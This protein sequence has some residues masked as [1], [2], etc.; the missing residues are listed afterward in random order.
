MKTKF[1]IL[2]MVAGMMLALSACSSSEGGSSEPE[3]PKPETPI[4]DDDWQTI[5]SDGGTI[6]KD[7]ITME[8][9]S[10]TFTTDSKVAITEVKQGKTLGEDEA[11][12]FYQ[13][14]MPV[15]AKRP[16]TI[17]VKCDEPADNIYLIT[18]ITT[19]SM[20][21]VGTN[22]SFPVSYEATYS[23]GEYTATLPAFENGDE[24]G[25]L[26]FSVGLAHRARFSSS[27]NL[28]RGTRTIDGETEGEI[29]WYFDTDTKFEIENAAVLAV[30]VDKLN[31]YIHDALKKINSLGFKISNTPKRRIPI[32]LFKETGKNKDL[33][34]EFKQHHFSDTKSW[35]AIKETMLSKT[36]AIS[37]MDIKATI[38]HE[39]LHYFQ[40]DYDQ[41]IPF[42][43]ATICNGDELMMYECGGKWIEKFVNGGKIPCDDEYKSRVMYFAKSL[44][45][46]EE[47]YADNPYA[48]ADGSFDI[49]FARQSHGY[50]MAT[51]IEYLA[52]FTNDNKIVDLYWTWASN[53]GGWGFNTNLSTLDCLKTFAI[54][55]DIGLFSGAYDSFLIDLADAQILP[56]FNSLSFY[57]E[58]KPLRVNGPAK[59]DGT[60]YPYGAD[61]KR[62]AVRI[63]KAELESTPRNLVIKPET[64]GVYT[65]VYDY[66]N[67][68]TLLTKDAI[69]YGDSLVVSADKLK[70]NADGD[71]NCNIIII[72]TAN[73]WERDKPKEYK[74][75]AEIQSSEDI[76]VTMIK[77]NGI[78]FD[79]SLTIQKEDVDWYDTAEIGFSEYWSG[80]DFTVSQAGDKVHINAVRI[81]NSVESDGTVF[82]HRDDLSFDIL[83]FSGNFAN[84]RIE[85]LTYSN[86]HD[87]DWGGETEE[88]YA[89]RVITEAS[90]SL[91][92]IKVTDSDLYPGV[93]YPGETS[94]RNMGIF[95]FGGQYPDAFT[96][97]DITQKDTY[98]MGP[99][100]K[101]EVYNSSWS[102]NPEDHILLVI[103]FNYSSKQNK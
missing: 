25:E 5:T 20:H 100:E 76:D 33:W 78:R 77:V 98:Y 43:K 45:N 12:P 65:Y 8:F 99:E 75:T 37:E 80:V 1:W 34:G 54:N 48:K 62:A 88:G 46:L 73:L 52:K 15:S 91:T 59:Y 94:K 87:I 58:D 83:G 13:I 23:N 53:T 61:A 27:A 90:C 103:D 16:I 10:G 31:G 102:K 26:F 92:D 50:A 69:V 60:I 57:T 21:L 63:S 19:P 36:D 96:I 66:D 49:G 101:K 38:Y 29:S 56:E 3:L 68:N 74:V 9:P 11:S 85:N 71:V 32:T 7:D 84:C 51:L 97:N 82:D 18:Y 6:E 28:C 89:S 79:T 86:K 55:N 24:E 95:R 4:N 67:N 35:F 2:T 14:V 64:E 47:A 17:S 30:T 39:L 72:N 22:M 81:Y 70:K 40:A 41:R 42:R 93:Q 44:T